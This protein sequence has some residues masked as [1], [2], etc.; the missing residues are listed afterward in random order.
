MNQT[1]DFTLF[2]NSTQG[3]HLT[4]NTPAEL[5]YSFDWSVFQEGDYELT[6]TFVSLNNDL[7]PAEPAYLTADFGTRVYTSSTTGGTPSSQVLGLLFPNVF[8][9]TE[10]HL[11]ATCQTNP[12]LSLRR[13]YNNQFIVRIFS[14]DGLLFVD[15]AAPAV[16]L[17]DYLLVLRFK[18]I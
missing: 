16:N 4:S 12:P 8:S 18:K 5:R 6:F 2:L 9:L 14:I 13:P 15:K 3:T 1:K 7:D 10:G 11:E 17:N